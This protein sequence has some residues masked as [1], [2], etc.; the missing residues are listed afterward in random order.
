[1]TDIDLSERLDEFHYE[2]IH[3]AWLEHQVLVFPEQD[4]SEENQVFFT[5]W[6]GELGQRVR[7]TAA[8]ESDRVRHSGTMLISNIREDG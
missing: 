5:Q 7:K 6:F 4:L 2:K 1:M 8:P 3:K